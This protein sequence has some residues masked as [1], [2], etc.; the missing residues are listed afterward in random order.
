MPIPKIIHQTWVDEDLP[1]QLVPFRSRL[2]DLHPGWDVRL[3][4]DYSTRNFVSQYYSWFLDVFDGYDSAIKRVDAARY[5]WLHHFGGIYVDLDIEPLAS[6]EGLVGELRSTI[7]MATEPRTHCDIYDKE[8]IVSNAFMVAPQG[9][10]FWETLIA[11]LVK[12]KD[13]EDPLY[14]T[15]PFLLT[16]LYEAHPQVQS[17]L[18]LLKPSIINPFDKFQCWRAHEDGITADL[19]AQ[20]PEES[21]AIHHWVGT[22][23]RG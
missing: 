15:G 17:T 11:E 23:W 13:Q 6:F 5:L 22:W 7:A 18:R 10:P 21:L 12:R 3:W 8:R 9:D 2:L 1:D 4:T 20:A 16:D 19:R 14:A